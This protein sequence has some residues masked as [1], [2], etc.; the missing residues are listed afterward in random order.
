MPRYGEEEAR[1]AVAASR[2]YSE[3][4]RRLGMRPAGGNHR[5]L[6]KY[7]DEIW[8]IPT[9]HFDAGG[10]A[11]VHLH[12]PPIPI[13]EILVE[14]STYSRGK[15]KQRLY[16]EGLK[17]RRCEMCGQEEC[18][19][20][21]WMSLILD[22]INGVPDDNRLENLRIVC[23]NCAA[24]L[25]THCGRKN[26]QETP[27]RTCLRCGR[28]F[29]AKYRTHRY[30]SRACGVR[31]DRSSLRG[32]PNVKARKAERPQY[33]QL[34][35]EIEANGY[36]AVGCKYGVSDNAVRKWVRFYERQIEREAVEKQG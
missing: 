20:G 29:A 34:L 13:K 31:W 14:G 25:D 23:P 19:R 26:R 32:K 22:H 30:C 28:E 7:V 18:W 15:L 21:R 2:S 9:D 1:R 6:R 10:S 3:V 36:V 5:L 24:T 8:C 27:I 4:L 16:D 11:I 17:Q 12:N 35:E 33:E